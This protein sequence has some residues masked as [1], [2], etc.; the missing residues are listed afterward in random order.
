MNINN[1]KQLAWLEWREHQR[2]ILGS[3]LVLLLISVPGFLLPLISRREMDLQLI[4]QYLERYQIL[5][6]SSSTSGLLQIILV[7]FRLTVIILTAALISPF[8]GILDSIS[9]EK[10]GRTIENLLVLP[11]SDAEIIS[12]KIVT[13]L[14]AGILLSWFLWFVYFSFMLFYSTLPVA[15]HLLSI[16]WL[17]LILLLVPAVALFMNLL[18]I[19]IAVQVQTAQAGYNLGFLVLFPLAV[20]LTMLGIGM[21]QFTATNLLFAS[22]FFTLL[23]GILFKFAYQ[24]FNREKIILKYKYRG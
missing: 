20:L 8:L 21:Y 16:T 24:T 12:G 15:F 6:P 5:H 18:G 3:I 23:D 14:L 22:G 9:S 17:V 2:R 19:I 4:G 7:D 11:L 1:I 13:C 10:E